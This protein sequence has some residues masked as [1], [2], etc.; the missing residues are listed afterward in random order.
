MSKAEN[1]IIHCHIIN[2][3]ALILRRRALRTLLKLTHILQDHVVFR[4]VFKEILGQYLLNY[5]PFPSKF[6][7]P[8]IPENYLV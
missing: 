6:T 5:I 7:P 4:I 3:S 1:F 8:L 2:C